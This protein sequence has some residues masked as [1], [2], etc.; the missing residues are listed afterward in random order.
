MR[1]PLI[2]LSVVVP[3][4][5][6][7]ERLQETIP[8]LIDYLK[9]KRYP[10]EIIISDDGSLVQPR[11]ARSYEGVTVLAH[12]INTGKGGAVRRGMLAAGGKYR[13][14]IDSDIPYRLDIIDRMLFFMDEKNYDLCI[15]DRTLKGSRSDP[16]TTILRYAIS[17]ILSSVSGNFLIK[18]F[19]DTQC[20]VKG[21]KGE[22]AS[23][24][25]SRTFCESFIFDVEVLLFAVKKGFR[26]QTLPV[27]MDKNGPSSVKIVRDSF[28]CG[29]DLLLIAFRSLIGRYS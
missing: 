22:V 18:G 1:D 16:P 23:T 27:V 15:G 7:N 19:F 26:I 10:W 24:I 14:F 8:T 20:G 25:F 29:V 17:T 21:F 28:R 4:F 6:D 2:H 9:S 11:I 3:C 13:V 12:Q 5:N